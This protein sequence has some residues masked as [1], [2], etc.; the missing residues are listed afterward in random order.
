MEMPHWD[1]KHRNS[2]CIEFNSYVKFLVA[3]PTP[4]IDGCSPI[5]NRFVS[6]FTLAPASP[7]NATAPSASVRETSKQTARDMNYMRPSPRQ[8]L[9]HLLDRDGVQEGFEGVLRARPFHEIETGN[10]GLAP[11]P[12]VLWDGVAGANVAAEEGGVNACVEAGGMPLEQDL[13]GVGAGEVRAGGD[14]VVDLEE[15]G[16]DFGFGGDADGGVVVG[17]V[18]DEGLE[19]FEDDAEGEGGECE[20]CGRRFLK[21]EERREDAA[22]GGLGWVFGVHTVQPG[23][24]CA[25][26]ESCFA[27]GK[28]ERVGC[29]AN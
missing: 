4:N 18:G 27:A 2:F 9:N 17:A 11:A 20:V 28:A 5:T 19:A 14:P 23:L 15:G 16:A 13:E 10:G 6:E 26:F 12:D 21:G 24:A 8:L 22:E 29:V 7:V 1:V 25:G 3:P